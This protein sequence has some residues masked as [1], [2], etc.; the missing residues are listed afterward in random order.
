MV[1]KLLLTLACLTPPAIDAGAA[2]AAKS[3]I[4]LDIGTPPVVVVSTAPAQCTSNT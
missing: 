2:D 3:A 4:N 1:K